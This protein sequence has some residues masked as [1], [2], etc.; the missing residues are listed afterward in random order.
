MLDRPK[1]VAVAR[2]HDRSIFN[3]LR[4]TC[5]NNQ[6]LLRGHRMDHLVKK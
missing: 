3:S 4:H 2:L 1:T 5:P 6:R